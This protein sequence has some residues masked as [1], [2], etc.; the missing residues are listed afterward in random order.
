MNFVKV[1]IE[2]NFLDSFLYSGVLFTVDTNGHLCTHSF[3]H[4]INSFADNLKCAKEQSE[5]KKFILNLDAN[6]KAH[7]KFIYDEK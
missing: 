6:G 1:K 3:K 2:G 7:T 4:L 5:L